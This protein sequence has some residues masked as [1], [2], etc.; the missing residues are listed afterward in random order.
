MPSVANVAGADLSVYKLVCENE[1]AY[2]RMHLSRD[3]RLPITMLK[4]EEEFMVS[5]AYDVCE[6]K[7]SEILN[8]EHL[9]MW[10]TQ[11]EYD[12]NAWFYTN[13]DARDGLP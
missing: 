10:F 2:N 13:A 3:Y 5:P 12:R 11:K 8:P 7:D 1:F 9:M 6:I 4:L